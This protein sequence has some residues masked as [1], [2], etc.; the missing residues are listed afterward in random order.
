MFKKRVVKKSNVDIS[1]NEISTAPVD[2]ILSDDDEQTKNKIDDNLDSDEESNAVLKNAARLR[3]KFKK[4]S[5]KN[6][7]KNAEEQSEN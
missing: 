4:N 7:D 6:T 1:F 2:E 5:E 3:K